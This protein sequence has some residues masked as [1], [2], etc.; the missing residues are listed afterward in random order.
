MLEGKKTE[1]GEGFLGRC[2]IYRYVL[3]KKLLGFLC[4]CVVLI[5]V[6][7]YFSVGLLLKCL[8]T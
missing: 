8:K 2:Y 6:L 5:I 4:V 7:V 3:G 1:G